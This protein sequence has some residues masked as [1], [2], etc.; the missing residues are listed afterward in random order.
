MWAFLEIFLGVTAWRQNQCSGKGAAWVADLH[1]D[2][3]VLPGFGCHSHAAIL[4]NCLERG[5]QREDV[6]FAVQVMHLH[7]CTATIKARIS[8]LPSITAVPL[9][10]PHNMHST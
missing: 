10:S 9:E 1:G 4:S 2:Q 3:N 5:G 7:L 6:V 8:A